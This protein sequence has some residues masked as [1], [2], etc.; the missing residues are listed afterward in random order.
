LE[1]ANVVGRWREMDGALKNA[2]ATRYDFLVTGMM[3]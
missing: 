3:S 2:C 1:L